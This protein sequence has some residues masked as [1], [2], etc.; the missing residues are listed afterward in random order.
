MKYS[1]E[2]LVLEPRLK[3]E[4]CDHFFKPFSDQPFTNFKFNIVQLQHFHGEKEEQFRPFMELKQDAVIL[5]PPP[6]QR[7]STIGENGF[8]FISLNLS[9]YLE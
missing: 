1:Q 7:S 2:Y 8:N 3:V 5:P 9:W 6:V 4:P